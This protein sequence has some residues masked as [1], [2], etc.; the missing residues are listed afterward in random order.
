[1]KRGRKMKKH[2]IE[3]L[4]EEFTKET[5]FDWKDQSFHDWVEIKLLPQKPQK[6][7]LH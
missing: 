3:Q 1:M 5:G 4:R 6:Q 2:W 7:N